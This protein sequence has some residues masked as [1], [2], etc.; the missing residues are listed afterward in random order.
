MPLL[1]PPINTK[2]TTTKTNQIAIAI[3]VITKNHQRQPQRRPHCHRQ[4]YHQIINKIEIITI[5]YG[6]VDRNHHRFYIQLLM[7]V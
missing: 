6:I 2:T 5:D 4:R 3:I 7:V 1:L